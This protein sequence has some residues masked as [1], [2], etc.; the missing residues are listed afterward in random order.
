MKRVLGIDVGDARVGLAISDEAGMLAHALETVTVRQTDPVRRIREVCESKN[1]GT[2]V[3]GLPRNMDG[4][5]GPA[6]EKSRAFAEKVR[7]IT[8]AEIVLWDERMTTVAAHRALRE[9]GRD[10][11][12]GRKV[13]DQLAAQMILQ[14]WMDAQS[15]LECS[16]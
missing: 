5:N 1:V 3:I 11:R 6:A 15:M 9:V 2:I 12:S 4:S 16:D 7:S 10:V 13:I 14:G 8:S